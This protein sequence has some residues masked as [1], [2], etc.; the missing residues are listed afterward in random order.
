MQPTHAE[1]ARTLAAGHLPGVAHIACRPGP[2]PVR[3]VTDANGRVLLLSP[4]DGAF[5]AALKPQEGNDDTAMV[6]DISDVPPM[7]GSP[8]L[9]R[10]WI[11]GWATLLEGDEARAA[12]LDYAD[13]DASG[14]LLDVGAGQVLHRMDVAEV[15]YERNENLVDVDVDDW[16]EATPDPLC[17]IEFDLIAD[18]LDHHEAEMSAY[19]RRQL[20]SA[21]QPK[22]EPQVVRMDRYGFMV[23]LDD[24]LARLAFPRPVTDRHDLAH[25]LH[26]VL[27]HRCG[28]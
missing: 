28:D 6:L 21:F 23:R 14:D 12:A 5:A 24:K 16:A 10:V 1:V 17:R 11:S 20:G 22:A 13:V 19:V 2:L 9:G 3:H 26:P 7:A 8:A 18:L 27:C 4:R 15:R 25:L